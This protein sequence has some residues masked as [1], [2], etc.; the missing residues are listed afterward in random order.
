[1]QKSPTLKNTVRPV[2]NM[3]FYFPVR[4]F[5][6]RCMDR[7]YRDTALVYEYM[8]KGD[9]SIQVWDDDDCSS[10]SLGFVRLPLQQI[11]SVKSWEKRNLRGPSASKKRNDEEDNEFAAAPKNLW[12]EED[13]EVRVYDGAK[14]ELIGCMLPNQAT[15]LIH[16]EAYFWPDY[17]EELQLQSLCRTL[18]TRTSGGTRRR[19]GT[20][21]RRNSPGVTPRPSQ[22]P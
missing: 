7:R 12:Y 14:S 1:M 11:F 9:I 22:T 19:F 5:N 4:L 15:P 13:K 17:P 18:A 6:P 2:F 3:I 8:I 20:R 16:F 21:S 10:D